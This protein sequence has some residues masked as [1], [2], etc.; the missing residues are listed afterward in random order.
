ML[1]SILMSILEGKELNWV[2]NQIRHSTETR[3]NSNSI[4]WMS[5]NWSLELCGL[6]PCNSKGWR[7]VLGDGV[8]SYRPIPLELDFCF[9]I[10]IPCATKQQN[11]GKLIFQIS[12]FRATIC[13][14]PN[15]LLGYSQWKIRIAL[16]NAVVSSKSG[17]KLRMKQWLLMQYFTL[18]FYRLTYQLH[19]ANQ[20]PIEADEICE[21]EA[22][23]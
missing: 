14:P 5:C 6:N 13:T 4:V 1:C 20:W 17:I 19:V 2:Q 3:S 23:R 9:Q 16:F 18:L 22:N 8:S 10:S 21:G 11:S 12:K 15:E 7:S